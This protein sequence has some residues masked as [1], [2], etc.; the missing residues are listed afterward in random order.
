METFKIIITWNDK[1]VSTFQ[2]NFTSRVECENWVK[3]YVG[4][5]GTFII[6]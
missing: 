3:Y 6:E 4:A 2:E 1:G 5:L